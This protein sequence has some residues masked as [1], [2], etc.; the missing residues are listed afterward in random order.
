MPEA[1][2]LLREGR[3]RE[4]WQKCCGFIDL[5]ITQFM[6]IQR[7]RLLEQIDLLGRCELGKRLM[8]G[9]A[10][11]TVE[12][13][14]ESVPLTTYADYASSLME[15]RADVL[16]EEPYLWQ[17]TSGRAGES[18]HQW[19][20]VTRRMYQE[21]GDALLAILIFATAKDREDIAFELPVRIL[22]GLAPPPYAT[23]TWGRRAE[24]ELI[25]EFLPPPEEAETLG[26][27]DTLRRGFKLGLAKGMD[28]VFGAGSVLVAAGERFGNSGRGTGFFQ[29]LSEPMA[30]LR[31][32]TG[33]LRSKLARRSLL[34]RDIWAVKGLAT[35][36]SDLSVYRERIKEMW[37][38]YPLEL[39]GRT[40]ASII[41]MQTW[42]YQ[43]M[44][45]LPGLNFLE[46]LPESERFKL[47]MD[48][49]HR[50]RTVLLDEVRPGANYELIITN[51]LGGPFV[52]Y[53]IGDVVSIASLRNERLGINLPQMSFVARADSLIDI[54]GFTRLTEKTIR[55]VLEETNIPYENWI[56][57]KE[58]KQEPVLHLYIE[59]KDGAA[60]DEEQMRQVVHARLKE[61]DSDYAALESMLGLRP[62]HVTVL[63]SGSFAHHISKKKGDGNG[64]H[65]SMPPHL[66][67]SDEEVRSLMELC[68]SH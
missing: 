39:Y 48:P 62:L 45:F 27:E 67:P 52:R 42:D 37:G 19:V 47:A 46:F 24:E 22:Y 38:R 16:P 1:L 58:L 41:A 29:L 2:E 7:R 30:L 40:E 21:L 8:G 66:N 68:G 10:P 20:P 18:K 64:P 11:W 17:W 31:L 34:P 35:V 61:I 43:T 26:F 5:D 49:S 33:L 54:A 25:F 44:T 12:E 56:A 6:N 4:L 14:R 3:H 15:R 23:G 9:G 65:R 57:R 63:P 51:L 50:P 32:G 59:L 28:F 13:F 36:S 53:R 55:R 60:P